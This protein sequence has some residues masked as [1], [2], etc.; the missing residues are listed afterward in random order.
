MSARD[1]SMHRLHPRRLGLVGR[2]DRRG[3]ALL[4]AW[5]DDE[6]DV[7]A[8]HVE[9]VVEFELSAD[10]VRAATMKK[11]GNPGLHAVERRDP[12]RPLLRER[13]PAA[14]DH[15]VAEP[16]RVNGAADLEARWRR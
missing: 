13:Q 2:L 1:D 11:F 8:L 12:V 16:R 5:R 15:L 14:P 7:P 9:H 6:R 4:G 10:L 3:A